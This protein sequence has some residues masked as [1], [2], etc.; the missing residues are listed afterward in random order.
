M[1]SLENLCADAWPAVA[2]ERV[3]QW[4]MRAAG[5]FTGRANSTLTAGDPGVELGQALG[6]A[7]EFARRHGIDPK[8]HVTVGAELE[9]ALPGQGWEL[10]LDHP[11]GVE[12]LVM[13]GRV[14]D[15]AGPARA[16]VVLDE[17]RAD[18]W[19]LATGVEDPPS[20]VRHV[21]SSAKTTGFGMIDGVGS[22]RG[23]VVED[24]LHIARLSVRPEFRRRGLARD[25]IAA[26]ANWAL[27]LGATRCALQVAEHNT[28]AIS[29]YAGLGC[30]EHHRY[31]YWTT[32][33]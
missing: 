29:L 15:L 24:L 23:A 19:R 21:L 17:A 4:R 7:A 6:S 28:A 1:L 9:R 12:S 16:A 25:L 33:R 13:T 10:D 18:W 8:L 3:G 14:A 32:T 11:G 26:L 31:Q 20:P 5:G 30:T 27:E 22:V 2:E